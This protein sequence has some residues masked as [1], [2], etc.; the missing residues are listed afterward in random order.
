MYIYIHK[1]DKCI[2]LY[3]YIYYI[4]SITNIFTCINYCVLRST[5]K[6][7]KNEKIPKIPVENDKKIVKKTKPNMKESEI[8]KNIGVSTQNSGVR[9]DELIKLL[10]RSSAL[11]DDFR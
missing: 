11:W 6:S 7:K 10:G 2:F 9:A 8:S 5:D 1:Y 3:S 4:N